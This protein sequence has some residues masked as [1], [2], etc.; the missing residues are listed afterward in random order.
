MAQWTFCQESICQNRSR[1]ADL[2]YDFGDRGRCAKRSGLSPGSF[3]KE[4]TVALY[5]AI[6]SAAAVTALFLG[7][8]IAKD[9]AA[10]QCLFPA[11]AHAGRNLFACAVMSV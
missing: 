11:S 7:Q 9:M 6:L 8:R 3:L 2:H 5:G 10:R 4:S 1:P